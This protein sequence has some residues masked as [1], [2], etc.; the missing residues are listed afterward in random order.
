MASAFDELIKLKEQVAKKLSAYRLS[1]TTIEFE[2]PKE[3]CRDD[4]N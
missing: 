4:A 2:F 3:T 1:H